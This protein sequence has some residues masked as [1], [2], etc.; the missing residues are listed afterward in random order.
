MALYEY[1]KINFKYC[2][3]PSC[4]GVLIID[5]SKNKKIGNTKD[6]EPYAKG[7]MYSFGGL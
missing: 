4:L 3:K 5:E 1:F 2:W 6:T 7:L